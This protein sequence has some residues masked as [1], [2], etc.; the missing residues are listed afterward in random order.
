MLCVRH[1]PDPDAHARKPLAVA[2]AY[3]LKRWAK[4]TLYTQNGELEID[5]PSVGG[6]QTESVHFAPGYARCGNCSVPSRSSR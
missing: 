5:N 3:S 2:A 1:G 6:Q 4:W